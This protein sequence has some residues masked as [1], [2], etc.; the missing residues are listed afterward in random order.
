MI[1]EIILKNRM[2]VWNIACGF[3][4]NQ[5]KNLKGNLDSELTSVL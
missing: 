3:T 4:N 5:V 2:L 1:L